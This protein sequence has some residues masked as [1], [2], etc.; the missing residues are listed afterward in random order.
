MTAVLSYWSKQMPGMPVRLP[1]ARGDLRGV[2]AIPRA[3]PMR[4]GIPKKVCFRAVHS[5]STLCQPQ[6]PLN[7][8][9]QMHRA[10][11]KAGGGKLT[12]TRLIASLSR[13]EKSKTISSPRKSEFILQA[14]PLPTSRAPGNR[15][16]TDSRASSEPR[17]ISAIVAAL[18]TTSSRFR[19]KA[20]RQYRRGPNLLRSFQRLCPTK[21]TSRTP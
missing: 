19:I 16:T 1:P 15:P 5:T 8:S 17:P 10:R 12:G 11:K 13:R 2:G 14:H 4:R 7:T 20:S 9:S 21:A 18:W 6:L 3:A